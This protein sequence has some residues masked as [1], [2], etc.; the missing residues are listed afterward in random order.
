MVDFLYPWQQ[1]TR[2]PVVP[3]REV[4]RPAEGRELD[5]CAEALCL[6]LIDGVVGVGTSTSLLHRDARIAR[7]HLACKDAQFDVVAGSSRWVSWIGT[8]FCRNNGSLHAFKTRWFLQRVDRSRITSTRF[9][10]ASD[11]PARMRPSDK[12]ITVLGGEW[13]TPRPRCLVPA[14]AR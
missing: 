9:I 10:R 13:E 6:G 5:A 3:T 12:L 1:R 2:R 11:A 7:R 8:A 14:N 4:E